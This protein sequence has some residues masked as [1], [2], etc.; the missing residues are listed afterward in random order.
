MDISLADAGHI[1]HCAILDA[2]KMFIRQV[3]MQPKF[4]T[5][6]QRAADLLA[7]FADADHKGGNVIRVNKMYLG[8][9]LTIG[10]DFELRL[11]ER[12]A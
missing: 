7:H 10:S 1:L 3:G 2:M 4:I 12:K 5:L 11:V 8:M 9:P 6:P